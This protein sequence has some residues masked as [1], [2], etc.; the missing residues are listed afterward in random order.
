MTKASIANSLRELCPFWT[1]CHSRYTK[2]AELLF[3]Q[4]NDKTFVVCCAPSL[5]LSFI[6][7]C[8]FHRF[9]DFQIR[10]S[11]FPNGF[12]LLDLFPCSVSKNCICPVWFQ[13]SACLFSSNS[14]PSMHDTTKKLSFGWLVVKCDRVSR[15]RMTSLRSLC[16][17][18]LLGPLRF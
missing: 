3:C 8:I 18:D 5:N 14:K 4:Q 7:I 1:L 6:P 11:G 2:G 13:T 16:R 15:L 10:R 12:S 17:K 9:L